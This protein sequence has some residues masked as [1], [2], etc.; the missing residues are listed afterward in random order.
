MLTILLRG[1][2]Q[3][4]FLL[5]LVLLS[6]G[7]Q[8]QA[9]PLGIAPPGTE[10]V[11]QRAAK[12][13]RPIEINILT[14]Y[15]EQTGDNAAVTGG[16]GTEA[17]TDLNT[18]LYLN[19]PLDSVARV[20]ANVGIDYYAS[21][22]TDRIDDILSSPSHADSRK[23]ADV[24]YYRRIGRNTWGVGGGFST[25][26]DYQ[27]VNL[28]GSWSRAVADGSAQLFASGQVFFDQAGLNTKFLPIELRSEAKRFL[29]ASGARR[30]YNFNLSYSQLLTRR[31]QVALAGEVAYQQGWLSTI[32][33]RVYFRDNASEPN[34]GFNPLIPDSPTLPHVEHLPGERLK[35]PVSLRLAWFPTDR[36][37][38][39][40]FYRRYT[41][42]WQMTANTLELEVPVKLGAF[43]TLYPLYRYHQQTAAT[44]FA[45]FAQHSITDTYYTS[46]YDLSA[47]TAH[48]LGAGVR[49]S[50]LRG[51]A[52][53]HTPLGKGQTELKGL[54]L[55]YAHYRRS[56]GLT[57]DVYTLD[58]S[59]V[60][61]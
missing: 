57:A 40:G 24:G 31:F 17:L 46:D 58:V 48:K 11:S 14:S 52:R 55:R 51:F 43:F 34:F 35:V 59:F 60:M 28:V 37:V 23:H 13:A 5:G 19:I 22:S 39:R 41:D 2:A 16:R 45:P 20:T 44:Y 26:Y 29:P 32:F 50:P 47:F 15:Y 54:D 7:V 3:L 1:R 33:H 9:P 4:P 30:S 10:A 12:G 56:T 27:S 42:S 6:F 49:W 36:L 53:F 8:A 18:T 21:A 61:P 38:V 25:E